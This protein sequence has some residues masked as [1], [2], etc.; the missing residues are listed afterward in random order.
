[1]SLIVI[2]TLRQATSGETGPAGDV[3][4]DGLAPGLYQVRINAAGLQELTVT[5][6]LSAGAE[7]RLDAV[8][9]PGTTRKDITI[10]GGAESPLQQSLSTSASIKSEEIKNLPDRP[11]S[12]DDAL[13]L[14]PAVLRLPNGL[15]S[16]TGSGEHRSTLLVNS[17]DATDPA[18]GQ[19]GATIPID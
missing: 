18:T 19:F 6:D 4:F 17:G 15:L 7:Q 14:A 13:P 12:V 8:L 5:V 16:I 1:V 9:V 10:E 2:V 11:A 3:R